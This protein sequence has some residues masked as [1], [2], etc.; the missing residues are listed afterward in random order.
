MSL[1]TNQQTKTT[2]WCKLWSEYVNSSPAWYMHGWGEFQ[3]DWYQGEGKRGG[4]HQPFYSTCVADF[5]LRQDAGDNA[6]QK[7]S[8]D[9][10]QPQS[11]VV[12]CKLFLKQATGEVLIK[13]DLQIVYI[14][15]FKLSTDRVRAFL[16][17]KGAEA[18]EQRHRCTQSWFS[19]VG[20]WGD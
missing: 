12:L 14:L 9:T 16:E 15:E 20:T 17:V 5:M 18:N 19:E 1:E 13:E 4:T 7:K 6:S 8:R 2:S 11:R 10:V 3:K